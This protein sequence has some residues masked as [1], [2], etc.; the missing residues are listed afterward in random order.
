MRGRLGPPLT[1]RFPHITATTH[2][3]ESHP[4]NPRGTGTSA[5]SRSCRCGLCP[6][7]ARHPLAPSVPMSGFGKHLT[8]LEIPGSVVST[9][10][11]SS[12]GADSI[13]Q[14]R[15]SLRNRRCPRSPRA[16]RAAHHA[17]ASRCAVS[18]QPDS[19]AEKRP[20][21][22][23]S[24]LCGSVVC[25]AAATSPDWPI[26]CSLVLPSSALP[27]VTLPPSAFIVQP[28]RS[29]L[30]TLPGTAVVGRP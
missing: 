8:R 12:A 27:P 28:S 1:A 16:S 25:T 13:R 14:R 21:A 24:H 23:T 26:G 18:R 3:L 22:C 20:I 30:D 17:C 19:D 6:T 11:H 10:V 2:S 9:T 7:T 4:F 5:A 29:S 15:S